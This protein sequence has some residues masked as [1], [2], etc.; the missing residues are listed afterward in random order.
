M[1]HLLKRR[2]AIK[3]FV[4]L[5][6]LELQ[7]RFSQKTFYSLEEVA[8]LLENDKYNKA[9]AAYAYGLFCSR[10]SFDSYFNELKVNCTSDGL[11]KIVAKKYFSG[12]IDFD[13][14]SI[15]RFAKGVGDK[16]YYESDLGSNVSD[17]GHSGHH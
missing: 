17:S 2:K 13:A 1:F 14:S 6:S 11:R 4:F 15:I 16:S 8:H 12:I 5:L 7:R 10:A 3:S 9:F